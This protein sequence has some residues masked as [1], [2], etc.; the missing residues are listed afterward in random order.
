VGV[1]FMMSKCA[2]GAI[3][4]M[5]PWTQ[6]GSLLF[7]AAAS[8]AK[9]GSVF[10][11]DMA[12]RVLPCRRTFA[13]HCAG[14]AGPA[15]KK[16]KC[17]DEE[18][19]EVWLARVV[20]FSLL[21][22]L[23]CIVYR[24]GGKISLGCNSAVGSPTFADA[25]LNAAY[26]ELSDSFRG[27]NVYRMAHYAYTIGEGKRAEL[28]RGHFF[29][30]YCLLA[31]A[32]VTD[33]GRWLQRKAAAPECTVMM[34]HMGNPVEEK[35]EALTC[36]DLRVNNNEFAKMP[37]F[38]RDVFGRGY[39]ALHGSRGAGGGFSIQRGFPARPPESGAELDAQL[40]LATGLFHELTGADRDKAAE[41][42]A[43]KQNAKRAKKGLAPLAH[44]AAFA[45]EMSENG[46][47]R[48]ARAHAHA[49]A[50]KRQSAPPLARAHQLLRPRPL[51]RYA[52]FLATGSSLTRRSLSLPSRRPA[53]RRRRPGRAR[54]QCGARG[55]REIA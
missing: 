42:L 29:A 8:A 18:E 21:Y 15:G 39:A 36:F 5:M 50:R 40:Q 31:C 45:A 3:I 14:G 4:A 38:E 43:A 55:G 32:A 48:T 25:A 26:P 19:V 20:S 41:A 49:H 34:L 16:G 51:V 44:A 37:N 28:A 46:E 2:A 35:A 23:A 12:F 27:D 52:S 7:A 13:S 11:F 22:G 54:G 9:F 33:V 1:A 30:G 6:H 53:R 24:T 10:C 47:Q 17:D